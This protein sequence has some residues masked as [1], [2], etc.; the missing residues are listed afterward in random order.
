MPSYR[1][2][3]PDDLPLLV[4]AVNECF[5]VHFPGEPEMTEER[6]R[7]EMKELDLWPSNSMLAVDDQEPVA[8]MIGTKRDD[9]VL[10]LRLGTRP[11]HERRGHASHLVM[12]LSHKLAVLGPPRLAAEVPADNEPTLALFRSIGFRE[13]ARLADWRS[14]PGRRERVSPSPPPPGGEGRGEGGSAPLEPAPV[15]DLLPDARDSLAWIRRRRTLENLADRLEGWR[16]PGADAWALVLPGRDELQLLA[17]GG[18]EGALSVLLRALGS[19][20]RR[21][22]FP[23]LAPGEASPELLRAAGLSPAESYHRLVGDA[24]PA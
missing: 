1:F 11:G 17:W 14:A 9:E 13:E 6:F 2:C 7:R 5:D 18:E 3:R 15:A 22:L 16:L 21:L 20:E 12:S 24:V 10:V 4:R 8:A 19:E 23:R